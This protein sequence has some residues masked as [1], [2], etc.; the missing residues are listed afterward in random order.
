MDSIFNSESPQYMGK[1]LKTINHC[2]MHIVKSLSFGIRQIWASFIYLFV[3]CLLS[4]Y[5]ELSIVWSAKVWIPKLL[6]TSVYLEDFSTT[7][8]E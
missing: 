5:Y 7:L 3:D 1:C 4:I 8:I 2:I 6:L